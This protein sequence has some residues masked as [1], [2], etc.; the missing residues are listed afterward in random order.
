MS[1][2]READEV[3][4]AETT[5][6]IHEWIESKSGDWGKSGR[7]RCEKCRGEGQRDFRFCPWCGRKAAGSKTVTVLKDGEEVNEV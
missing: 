4:T 5:V 7:T 1:I 2:N 6:W 3:N